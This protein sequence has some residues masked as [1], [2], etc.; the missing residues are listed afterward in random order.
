MNFCA[1]FAPTGICSGPADV[2]DRRNRLALGWISTTPSVSS[3]VLSDSPIERAASVS[4][5]LPRGLE[6]HTP[7]ICSMLWGHSMH[8]WPAGSESPA[9]ALALALAL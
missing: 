3:F 6:A 4:F 7:T 1:G 9:L 8:S 5:G 2:L